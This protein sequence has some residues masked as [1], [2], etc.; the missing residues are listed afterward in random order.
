M[1]ISVI[2]GHPDIKSFNYAIAN[3][4]WSLLKLAAAE[5]LLFPQADNL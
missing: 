3:S 4:A 1:K 5:S 2:L